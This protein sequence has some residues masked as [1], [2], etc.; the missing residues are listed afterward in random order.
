MTKIAVFCNCNFF[1]K[2]AWPFCAT[3][4]KEQR[5]S[6]TRVQHAKVVVASTIFVLPSLRFD[7]VFDAKC[8]IVS[9]VR[10]VG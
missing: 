10:G 9:D 1:A 2:V 3:K 7:L 4:C 8:R 5:I 6:S